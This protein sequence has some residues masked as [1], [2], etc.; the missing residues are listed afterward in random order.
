ML[1]R[2]TQELE[3]QLQLATKQCEEFKKG[4]TAAAVKIK[5]MEEMQA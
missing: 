1:K 2:K 3:Q 4:D 5:A